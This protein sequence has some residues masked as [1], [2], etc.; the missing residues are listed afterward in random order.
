MVVDQLIRWANSQD[1]IRAVIQKV[2]QLDRNAQSGFARKVMSI[3]IIML[4]L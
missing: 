4:I 2:Q 3:L 1:L